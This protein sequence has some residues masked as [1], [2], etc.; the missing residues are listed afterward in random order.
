MPALL[1]KHILTVLVKPLV[2]LVNL[3]FCLGKFPDCLKIGKVIPVHKKQDKDNMT[4]YRPISVPSVFSKIFEYCFLDRLVTFLKRSGIL[5]DN[6]HG[7]CSGRSTQTAV[8]EFY[9]PLIDLIDSGECPVGIFCDLSR[10]FDC[11]DH[12]LLLER[13]KNYGISGTSLTWVCSFISN[14]TQYVSIPTISQGHRTQVN[15]NTEQI[16][17]GVPQGSVL[18]P[19]LFLVYINELDLTVPNAYFSIYADDTSLLV[20]DKSRSVTRQKCEVAMSSLSTWFACNSLYFNAEKTILLQFHNWQLSLNSLE[21]AH[22]GKTIK[23]INK[24]EYTKFLGLCIDPCLTWQFHCDQVIGRLNRAAYLINNLRF[25]LT[26]T[27]LITI[28]YAYVESHLRYGVCFW[29]LA[30][31]AQKVFLA[32]KRVVRSMAGVTIPDSCKPFFPRYGILTLPSLVILELC[33]YVFLNKHKFVLN[34]DIH[35]RYTRQKDSI[36]V[37]RAKGVLASRAPKCMGARLF[38]KLPSPLKTL[39]N[40][41]NFKKSLKEYLVNKCLYTVDQFFEQ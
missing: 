19:V 10:A 8:H 26:E 33:T 14:R 3:S 21:V 24:N 34:R 25:T 18:G 37:P 15:S 27:Q 9:E 5:S 17:L 41:G 30:T 35:S 22:D 11:V 20:S 39:E 1:V 16:N 23:T 32:Q 29:G 31:H 38:N 28:Y 7:Y 6:Q 36:H 12:N 40:V 2:H 4:N 13:L